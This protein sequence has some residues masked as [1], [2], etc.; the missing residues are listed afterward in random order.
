MNDPAYRRFKDY[1]I[2]T[3]GLAYYLNQDEELAGRIAGRLAVLGLNQVGEY[4]DRLSD[5]R[6]AEAEWS[7]LI[8]ELTIGETFFFRH[9]EQFDALRDRVLPELIEHQ[10]QRRRLKIWSAG[11]AT[12]AEPYS[13]AI[14]LKTELAHL[15]AGWDVT[16]VGTDINREFLARAQ[17]AAFADWAFRSGSEEVKRACFSPEGKLWALKPE[18]KQGVSFQY[19]NL[20]QHPFPSL[21][22]NLSAFDLILCRNVMIYFQRDIVSRIIE[23]FHECLAEGGWLLVGH[24]ESCVQLFRPFR[25][26]NVPGAVLYQKRQPAPVAAESPRTV[27]GRN[28]DG[29]S[30]NR[31]TPSARTAPTSSRGEKRGH[32]R[33]PFVSVPLKQPTT[34]PAAVAE[35]L[36]DIRTK[37]DRAQWEGAARSCDELIALDEL[38]PT[39]HFYQALVLEQMGRHAETERALRRTIYLDRRFVL[40]HYHL[41]LLLQMRRDMAGAQR[42]FRNAI[43]LLNQMDDQQ[44]FNDADG[45]TV[46]ALKQWTQTHLEVLCHS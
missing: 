23:Q 4:L 44:V 18:F 22:N 8:A 36:A 11:C 12:G 9:R 19:H 31:V 15:L 29:G 35:R 2:E 1:V 24:A 3:T 38:N 6:A 40:A 14:L 17:R 16:I 5:G 13:I 30:M 20:V 10:Q 21:L 37:A 46:G 42:C 41:G 26:L 33:R 28:E 7:A 45:L 34:W 32:N 39:A 27:G 43:K 25:T